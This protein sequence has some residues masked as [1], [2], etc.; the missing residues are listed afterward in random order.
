MLAI[1][2]QRQG[3][4]GHAHYRVIVQ[5][6]RWHPTNNKIVAQIGTYDPHTKAT[7]LDTDAAKDF[8]TN[9]AHP[10][11]RAALLLKANGVKLPK[12]VVIEKKAKRTLRNPEKLRK[13]RPAGAPA[14]KPAAEAPAAETESA[15]PETKAEE[16]PSEA[17]AES[18]AETA[19]KP[20][21][22]VVPEADT[23]SE[24]TPAEAA[25]EKATPAAETKEET[26]S[27]E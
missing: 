22:E 18:V 1:R 17:V 24:E 20:A 21:E 7:R 8:L 12:W 25:P 16:T 27:K 5:D 14:P 15:P 4:S 9:G 10:S 11:T 6:S 23:K 2:L 26:E 19:E 3:R 13:N